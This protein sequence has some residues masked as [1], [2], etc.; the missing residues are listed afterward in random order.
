MPRNGNDVCTNPR[1]KQLTKKNIE[2]IYYMKRTSVRCTNTQKN[3]RIRGENSNERKT[4]AYRIERRSVRTHCRPPHKEE[5]H[6]K[7]GLKNY[8]EMR[9]STA[10]IQYT[11]VVG[12]QRPGH[13][14]GNN[15][16][17]S[18]YVEPCAWPQNHGEIRNST[19][20]LW[21]LVALNTLKITG[22]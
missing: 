4:T 14:G 17:D 12:F 7:L 19:R 21:K 2:I 1:R 6:K 22:I 5:P 16:F 20:F 10:V 8:G 3:V 18:W 13:H 11:E 15:K 9:N